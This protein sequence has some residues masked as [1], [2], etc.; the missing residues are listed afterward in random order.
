MASSESRDTEH[1]TVT[2]DLYSPTDLEGNPLSW[3]GNYAKILGLIHEVGK[4]LVR[5]GLLQPY[6]KHRAVA[7]NNGRTSV[8]SMQSVPFIHKA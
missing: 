8:Y 5:K 6:I 2:D 4:Y 7:L 3:D 1:T